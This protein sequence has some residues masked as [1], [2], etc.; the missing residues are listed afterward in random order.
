MKE[1]KLHGEA[2]VLGTRSMDYIE[3]LDVKRVMIV[4]GQSSASKSGVIAKIERIFES[5]GIEYKLFSGIKKNPDTS[6]VMEGLSVMQSFMPD[7]VIGVGGGSPIDAAKVMVLLYDNPELDIMTIAAEDIT[8]MKRHTM[9]VAVPSTSGTG[10]EVT[11][12]AVITYEKDN[13][14]IGLKSK[15]FIPDI[16]ILDS[17]LT[18]SMP[19]NV[20][21]E[22][23][24]DAMTHAVECFINKNCD[25]FAECLAAGA[26][27]GLFKHLAPSYITGE[28]VHRQKVH[29]YQCM[30]GCA[31]AN[32]G[33]GMAHGIAHAV[34]GMYDIGHGL[35]N[36]VILP[37]VL[38]YNS[39]DSWVAERLDYLANRIGKADFTR[40]IIE[41]NRELNIPHGFREIGI[42]K[43]EFEEK[44]DVLIENSMKGSTRVNP[45]SISREEMRS[46]LIRIYTG[47]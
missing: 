16:A 6:V 3:R 10:T 17:D 43:T 32:V 13:L 36:A 22:T 41:L 1:L 40:A 20:V 42:G 38:E 29:N 23:G 8:E 45:V 47:R 33:L 46:L 26:V 44:L 37:F 5:K 19:R 7:C 18:I 31:F 12:S 11:R 14:K 39:K 27:E 28:N 15:A 35:L 25:D 4:T 30:A 9:L 2:I 34:G 21:A 24:M